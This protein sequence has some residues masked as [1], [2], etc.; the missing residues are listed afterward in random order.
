VKSTDE[1]AQVVNAEAGFGGSV[2]IAGDGTKAR[3]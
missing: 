3:F 2:F 1:R